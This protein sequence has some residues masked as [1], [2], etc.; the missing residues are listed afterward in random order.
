MI[1]FWQQ[2]DC[3][4]GAPSITGA[5]RD[6]L[7]ARIGDTLVLSSMSGWCAPTGEF[8][9]TLIYRLKIGYKEPKDRYWFD[10]KHNELQITTLPT[11]PYEGEIELIGKEKIRDV[12]Q[13]LARCDSRELS[14]ADYMYQ[15]AGD[16]DYTKFSGHYLMR[17][18]G[19]LSEAPLVS[20]IY[21]LKPSSWRFFKKITTSNATKTIAIL[22]RA[23]AEIKNLGE[24]T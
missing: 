8:Q 13:F 15:R 10:I 21:S 4:W 7:R 2:N 18:S 20:P 1:E 24:N 22:E 23:I 16:L 17:P 11:T 14:K 6:W 3:W 19:E 5:Q 12:Q 9:N